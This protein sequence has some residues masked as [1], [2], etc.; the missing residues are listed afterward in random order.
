MKKALLISGSFLLLTLSSCSKDPEDILPKGDGKWNIEGTVS[1]SFN[2]F[3]LNV[4]VTGSATFKTDK[5]MTSTLNGM[6]YT[7]NVAGTWTATK[8]S[9]T[10]TEP[11]KTPVVWTVTDLKSDSQTW[12]NSTTQDGTTLN[13]KLYLKK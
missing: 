11:N 12:T 2:G 5:T 6:G 3:P 7:Q 4:A 9:V 8:T 1:T 10:I 13:I